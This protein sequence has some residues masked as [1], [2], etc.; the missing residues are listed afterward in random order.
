MNRWLA[1]GIAV[2]VGLAI[3]FGIGAAVYGD[4]EPEE[5]TSGTDVAT[6]TPEPSPVVSPD[7]A[8]QETCLAALDAAEQDVQAEERTSD[9]L[10]RYETV[11]MQATEALADLDTRRL[12]ELLTEVEQL[13]ERSERL[14]DDSRNADISS[15]IETCRSVLGVNDI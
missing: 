14:I 9:L 13:N 3:G 5:I 6:T 1:A 4:D 15:A 7:P 11:I 8:A 10:D 12:E 2:V